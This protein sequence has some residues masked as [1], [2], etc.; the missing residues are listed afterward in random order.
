MSMD[1]TNELIFQ[2]EIIAQMVAKGWVCGKSDSYDRERALFSQDAIAFVQKTQPQE[3]E[4]FAR[5]Y[6]TDTERHFLD[7]LVAQ[8]KKADNNATDILSRTY[9]TLGVLRH[10]IKS[11]SARFSLCQFKPEHNLNP[12]TLARY[13]QNICRVVPELV[14]SPYATQAAFEEAGIKAKKWRIDLVLFINGLPVATLELKSE[15]KQAVQNAIKQYK[16]TRLPKDPITN[17]PEPLLTFKRGALV[18]L[19]SAS[20]RCL[21]RPNWLAMTPSS[22]RLTKAPKMAAQETISPK[23]KMSTPPA[24]CGMKFYCQITC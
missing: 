4:K 23:M 22:C 12:E 9:G 24:T 1:T 3:W 11:H 8:L 19:P 5:I 10:G 17:K 2:N 13:Q 16:K 20:M 7:V 21:W 18:H 14:Y 6:P 15:F